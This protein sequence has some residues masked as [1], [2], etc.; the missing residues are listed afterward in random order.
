MARKR[1]RK[2]YCPRCDAQLDPAHA[3]DDD[4]RCDRCDT[5]LQPVRVAGFWRRTLAGGLDLVVLLATAGLLNWGLLRLTGA[6]PLLGETSGLAALLAVLDLEL[7][8]VLRRLAPF[9]AMSGLYLGLFWAT[10][11][12]TLG[13]RVF[14]IRVLDGQ[15]HPPRI[16]IV[17]VRV[18]VHLLG[19]GLG[20]L[21]WTWGALDPNKRGWHDHLAGTFVVRDA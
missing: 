10:T 16:A 13:G 7:T 18:L 11:G 20:L 3:V 2:T 19:L 17:V 4:P 21:G 6:D 5:S 15:G 8:S 14:G 1:A 12:R 9:L